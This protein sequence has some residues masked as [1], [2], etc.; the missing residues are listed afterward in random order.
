MA[1]VVKNLPAS[2]GDIMRPRFDPWVVKIPWRTAWQPIPVFLPGV[3][4]ATV[5]RVAEWDMTDRLLQNNGYSS[6]CCTVGPCWLSILYIG[7]CI[8]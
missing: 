7:M 3:W 4:Q 8:C 1:L 6:L 2:A 5:H